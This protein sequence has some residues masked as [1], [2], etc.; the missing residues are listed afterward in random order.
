MDKNRLGRESWTL[1]TYPETLM[2]VSKAAYNSPIRD[3]SLQNHK[4]AAAEVKARV[5][6]SSINNDHGGMIADRFSTTSKANFTMFGNVERINPNLQSEQKK[7][8]SQSNFTVGHS[9]AAYMTTSKTQFP[10]KN[11]IVNNIDQR[12]KAAS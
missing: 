1:G 8:L 2:T 12:R 10:A 4:D 9:P 7:K 11:T 6:Q 3:G 5:G